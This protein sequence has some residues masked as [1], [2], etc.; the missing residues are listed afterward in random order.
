VSDNLQR[1]G[2]VNLP[3]LMPIIGATETK[4]Y[5]N[6]IEYTFGTK[7]FTKE[8]PQAS[9]VPP[10]ATAKA[11]GGAR[12]GGFRGAGFHAKGFFDKIVDIETCYLQAEPTNRIRLAVKKFAIDNGY[13]FYDIR[14]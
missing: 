11:G 6:K 7:E 4:F 9:E 2:K 1:I 10:C 12:S 8:K 3:P 14:N 13:S 5:R